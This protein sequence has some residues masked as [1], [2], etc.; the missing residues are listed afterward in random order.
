MCHNLRLDGKIIWRKKI[1]HGKNSPWLVSLWP[2]F[3]CWHEFNSFLFS[4]SIYLTTTIF[5][6][7]STRDFIIKD[8]C[9]EHRVGLQLLSALVS[10]TC[11]AGAEWPGMERSYSGMKGIW[12]QKMGEQPWPQLVHCASIDCR[13]YGCVFQ[14]DWIVARSLGEEW[15][16]LI[17]VRIGQGEDV[18]DFNLRTKGLSS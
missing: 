10:G 16:R 13:V 6:F 7:T 15:Y 11:G 1:E 18:N 14:E 9:Y 4:S 8:S 12:Q 17:G 2:V 3:T 5:M